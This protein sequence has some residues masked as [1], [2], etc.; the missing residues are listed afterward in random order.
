MFV[1]VRDIVFA[2]GRVALVAS[3]VALITILLIMLSGLTN[4]L[5]K[6]NT[7][8]LETLDAQRIV[9]GPAEGTEEM[10]SFTTSQ[11]TQE[12]LDAWTAEPAVEHAEPLVVTLTQVGSDSKVT[13]GA[14]MGLP[15]DSM[16]AQKVDLLEGQ[17]RPDDGQIVLSESYT[18]D[19]GI[20]LGDTVGIGGKDLEV[21]GFVADEFY[22]HL[23][24][25]WLTDADALAVAHQ[26]SATVGTEIMVQFADG[27][28]SAQMDEIA[29]NLDGRVDTMTQTTRESFQAIP[30]Y[31]SENGS[32]MLM[33]AFLYG[34][35]ALVVISF[36]TVWTVQRTR[37]VAVL[38]ALGA[39]RGY[40]VRDSLVQATLVVGLGVIIGALMGGLMGWLVATQ[41][42]AVPFLFSLAAVA[43]PALG[44]LLLGIVGSLL[45]VR[46]VAKV[47]P[48][49]AL[50]GN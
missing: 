16:F 38:R 40:L 14:V 29:T 35:S 36:I 9:F 45:A 50:G 30:S 22:S 28:D 18:A 34:I 24:V 8:A 48:M 21:V 2:K 7:A 42:T 39:S 3:V 46:R 27:T 13:T 25:A 11:I 33:L 43:I 31:S 49:I 6:Q 5:G 41:V 37:D 4:G 19:L 26:P 47:D 12:Q 1:S 44:V 20:G 23:P 17:H 10:P 32:L 15:Q